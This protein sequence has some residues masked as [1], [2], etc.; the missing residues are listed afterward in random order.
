MSFNNRLCQLYIPEHN[1]SGLRIRDRMCQRNGGHTG[2]HRTWSREWTDGDLESHARGLVIHRA[3]SRNITLFG[4]A[5]TVTTTLCGRSNQRSMDGTN[6][7]SEGVT[8]KLCLLK[9]KEAAQ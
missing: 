8:C 2:P 7:S 3:I 6:A 9:M 5:A 1:Y 4:V